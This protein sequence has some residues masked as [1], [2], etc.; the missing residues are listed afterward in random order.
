MNREQKFWL[1][2][3]STPNIVGSA[4]G[5]LGL[6]L[7]FAG[8]IQQFWWLI[9][10]GLYAIGLLVTPVN[11]QIDLVLR[12]QMSVEELQVELDGLVRKI[13]KRVPAE[14]LDKVE[15]IKASIVTILPYIIDV[16]SADHSV[17]IIRQTVLEYL[18]EA[19]QN[20]M[21]LPPAFANLHVVRNNKTARQLLGDQL[22]LLDKQMEEV[23]VD[24]AKNDTQKLLAHGRFLESKFRKGDLLLAN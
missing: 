19:L 15:H 6:L 24:L 17:Y 1:Y 5:I 21:N 8:V 22:D 14:I 9:V 3:Y 7:F 12:H 11:Q 10:P 13:R 4:L 2:L 16:N 20:Y 23:A 18:P